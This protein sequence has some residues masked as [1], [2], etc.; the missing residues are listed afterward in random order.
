MTRAIILAGGLGQR[1]RTIISDVPK[2]M[3]PINGKP[4]LAYQIEQLKR[5]DI[6][7]VVL[8]I[9]YLGGVIVDYF[10]DYYAGIRITYSIESEPMGTGG[11]MLLALEKLDSDEHVLLLNGDTYFDINFHNL[12][13][14]HERH[15]AGIS[16]ALFRANMPERYGLVCAKPNNQIAKI[17]SEKARLNE[18]AN[19]GVYIVDPKVIK[20]NYRGRNEKVS[21]EKEIFSTLLSKGV[22]IVGFECSGNFID[23][24]LPEDYLRAASI[25]LNKR[26]D[27]ANV[28]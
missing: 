5:F 27:V 19:G 2:P 9:G 6:D 10:R 23:I 25:M 24:G 28:N 22:S 21:L 8:S 3:A 14:L 1:L 12:M 7:H 26:S 4:F 17:C 20:G 18:L 11:G 13:Q 15:K 16:I